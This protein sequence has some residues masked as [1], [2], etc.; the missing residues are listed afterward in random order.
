MLQAFKLFSFFAI[1]GET[2]I[3]FR[4]QLVN[5]RIKY[6]IIIIF[7]FHPIV[8][9]PT[10]TH[11]HHT[12]AIFKFLPACGVDA[13]E[14]KRSIAITLLKLWV[15]CPGVSSH[16]W[17]C[18]DPSQW[19][20]P[21]PK[22]LSPFLSAHRLCPLFH[23]RFPCSCGSANEH[24]LMVHRVLSKACFVFVIKYTIILF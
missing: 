21:Q 24:R 19:Y 14:F 9:S 4:A 15:P 6:V 23:P 10:G 7:N 3:K 18:Q 8:M 22:F 17:R 12:T 11:H 16:L 1:P 2:Q 5:W 20:G 13:I